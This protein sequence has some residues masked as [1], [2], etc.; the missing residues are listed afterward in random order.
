MAISSDFDGVPGMRAYRFYLVSTPIGN[1]G[2][3]S[4][5]AVEVLSSVDE[6]L[7][8]DTRT[9]RVLF[10]RYGISTPLRSYNDH[11]KERVTPGILRE[12]ARG[13]TF[14]LVADAGTPLVSDP[15]YYIVR[16]LIDAG[17]EI[18]AV[19]GACSVT[20]A[21]SLSG[22]PPDR[23][24]FYGYV[25]RKSGERRRFLE[26]V[27]SNPY[28]SILFES[29]HRLSK[30]LEAFAA[31]L[32]EREVVVARELTKLHEEVVR[33]RATDLLERFSSG[34]KG[35]IVIL[36]RGAGRRKTQGE[37]SGIK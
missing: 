31:L 32:P 25:P 5:R 16:K 12:V 30:T 15:G 29:P 11:N 18:T 6:V 2:D 34:V 7:A 37:R 20:T 3:L 14:A 24:T 10:D 13:K 33:G 8:E 4:V 1:L 35:E 19:P 17:V 9:A 22:L 36:V 26:E 23:F 27:A 28:T 21:L